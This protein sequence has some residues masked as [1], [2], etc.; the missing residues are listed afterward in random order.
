MRTIALVLLF[1][2]IPRVLGAQELM[3][4]RWEVKKIEGVEYACYG[5][6]NVKILV[7]IDLE[8]RYRGKKLV[9]CETDK[10]ALLDSLGRLVDASNE[11]ASSTKTLQ[12]LLGKK[13][14]EIVNL[15]KQNTDLSKKTIR[16]N[17]SWIIS[18]GLMIAVVAFTS[19]WLLRA[20]G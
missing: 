12:D 1:L 18:S 9:A 20:K 5:F 16:N 11:Q 15:E 10:T 7:Q 2:F 17:L 14:L 3:L 13:N 8:L 19:G 6:E 4:P